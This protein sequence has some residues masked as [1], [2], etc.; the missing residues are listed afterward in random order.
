MVRKARKK[1]GGGP[2]MDKMTQGASQ[3]K[4]GIQTGTSKLKEKAAEAQAGI[5]SGQQAYKNEK[6]KRQMVAGWPKTTMFDDRTQAIDPRCNKNGAPRP[7]YKMVEG[8]GLA[9]SRCQHY[10]ERASLIHDPFSAPGAAW[11]KKKEQAFGRS[12]SSF[13]GKR[14]TKR[15]R[16]RRKRRKTKRRK[17]KRRKTKRRKTRRRR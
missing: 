13:G 2:F 5:A 15:R 4:Q 16:K 11:R 10:S 6:I 8:H 14:K 7:G 1:K 12:F 3:W 9:E 17:T